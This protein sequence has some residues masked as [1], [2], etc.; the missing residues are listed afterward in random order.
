MINSKQK[1]LSKEL[2]QAANKVYHYRRDVISKEA[3]IELD[4]LV[5][6]LNT[7]IAEKSSS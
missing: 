5:C 2:L 3:I 4:R 7:L 6:E 1:K